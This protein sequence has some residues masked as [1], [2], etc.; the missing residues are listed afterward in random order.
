[1]QLMLFSDQSKRTLILR[2]MKWEACFSCCMWVVFLWWVWRTQGPQLVFFIPHCWMTYRRVWVCHWRRRVENRVGWRECGWFL[3]VSTIRFG[4]RYLQENNGN[5]RDG[6]RRC[7]D[8]NVSWTWEHK[9]LWWTAQFARVT[10]WRWWRGV[11]GVQCQK[12]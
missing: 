8:S 10:S 7:R 3:G 6:C 1:M 11:W 2:E 9:L 5:T 4:T 12:L